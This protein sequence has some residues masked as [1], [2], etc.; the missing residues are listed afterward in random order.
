MD[1]C[2]GC[3]ANTLSPPGTP[4]ILHCI[5]RPG[6]TG[7][8]GGPCSPCSAGTFKVGNGSAGCTECPAGTYSDAQG[9]V[10]VGT[11]E[12]CP[13]ASHS[14]AGSSNLFNCSCSAG[15]TG[16]PTACVGCSPG[17]FK[18]AAGSSPCLPC[19]PGTYSSE[20]AQP[21]NCSACPANTFSP[22]S[23]DGLLKCICNAGYS[24]SDG[25]ACEECPMGAYKSL[26]GSAACTDCAQGKYSMALAAASSSVCLACPQNTNSLLRSS[27]IT[28]CTCNKGYTGPDGM[29]CIACVAGKYKDVNGSSDCV[30]CAAGKYSANM[31]QESEA[32]CAACPNHTVSGNG[33]SLLL[34]CTC[35]QGYT[36]P[37]GQECA[38][39]VGGWKNTTG[40]AACILCPGG[41]YALYAAALLPQVCASCPPA[42]FSAAGSARSTN[43]LCNAGYTGP[44]GGPCVA[45]PQGAYKSQ[46]GSASCSSCQVR[47]ADNGAS[48]GDGDGDNH[49][50]FI[51]Y[52]LLSV[53][54]W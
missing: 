15:Y 40:S 54:C 1:Q 38:A 11:C 2:L 51:S 23:S 53:F 45:C 19:A 52:L 17:L 48:D 30:E 35:K 20:Y 6:H 10:S 21:G 47:C 50:D 18:T 27:N 28:N 39:C 24:G 32:A 3:A 31:A 41:T 5:C 37:D 8:N 26:N 49:D 36:G 12:Q 14:P 43:C 46:S 22:P 13:T 9:A 25:S 4:D 16:P 42:S 34:D 44:L 7:P 29:S 33:S